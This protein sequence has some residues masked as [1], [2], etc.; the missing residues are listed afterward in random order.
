MLKAGDLRYH[1][2][3]I[4][5]PVMTKDS[6][7]SDIQEWETL[8]DKVPAKMV[9]LSVSQFISA[10]AQQSKVRG[11]FVIRSRPG[12]EA[13]HRVVTKGVAYDI[14]GWLPDPESGNEYITAPY[15]TGVNLGGF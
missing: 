9:P 1:R 14:E 10:D 12:L 7:G 4:Q 2:L 8:Y 15:G 11:R 5:V 3:T 13:R 6:Q